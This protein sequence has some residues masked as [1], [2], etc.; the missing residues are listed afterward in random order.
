MAAQPSSNNE[1]PVGGVNPST[2]F[3]GY[4]GL[5]YV[6]QQALSKMQTSTLVRIEACTNSGGLAEVGL[7]DVTPL[8]NQVDSVG[9]PIEHKTIYNVPYFRLQGG[10]NAVI[11]DPEVGD[12]GICVFAS[13]DISKV[14][15]TKTRANPDSKR[16]YSYSDGLYI[17][18]VLNG[19]PTQ[20]VQFSTAGIKILSPT[21]I[22]LTAPIV[23]IVAPVT[24]VN[25]STSVTITTPIF[26]VNG[27]T[28]I[29]GATTIT[30]A[31]EIVGA[32]GITGAFSIL[33]GNAATMSG[34][35]TTTGAMTAQGTNVHTHTHTSSTA[36]SPTSPPL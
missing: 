13:R 19:V 5:F 36:G 3:G 35:L 33:G 6:I 8:V 34:S 7:V 12:I 21:K 25:S 11:I 10:A 15:K 4:N 14:K 18:G 31:T 28:E 26:T 27:V 32:T 22:N 29:N 1:S 24:T 20:Y 9:I 16:S 2:V 23:E 30:G 17:G